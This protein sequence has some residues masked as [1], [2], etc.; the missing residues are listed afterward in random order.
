MRLIAR[1]AALASLLASLLAAPAAAQPAGDAAA[2]TWKSLEA[3]SEAARQHEK[4]L[5][6]EVYAPWCG[7]C[8]KM[9]RV[10]Y[11]D[12]QVQA[13]L[14][15]HFEVTRLNGEEPDTEHRLAGASV[16]TRTMMRRYYATGY[17]TTAFAR[18]DGTLLRQ[19][20]GFVEP[21]VF[22]QVLR[23]MRTGAYETQP[24]DAFAMP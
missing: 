3:A 11:A 14:A 15:E 1:L 23:Y 12:P 20:P 22:L 21:G 19:I 18:P 8:R 10:T 9:Q 2:P 5:L 4:L 6:V 16:T 13:Y 7:Y 17:P 24:F